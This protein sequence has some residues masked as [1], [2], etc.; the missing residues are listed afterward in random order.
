[1]R[2][3]NG[4]LHLNAKTTK[5]H[6]NSDGVQFKPITNNNMNVLQ[7]TLK[8]GVLETVSIS[9]HLNLPKKLQKTYS[10]PKWWFQMFNK[11]SLHIHQSIIEII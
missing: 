1:M 5:Q 6:V 7:S 2:I 3:W 9:W 4:Q 8:A 10:F 11:S